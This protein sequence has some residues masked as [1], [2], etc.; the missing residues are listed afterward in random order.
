MG[1]ASAAEKAGKC[2]SS[3]EDREF[4]AS[5]RESRKLNAG[6]PVWYQEAWPRGRHIRGHS[7]THTDCTGRYLTIT[8][9][10]WCH[11]S[12]SCW[13]FLNRFEVLDTW[14]TPLH[15]ATVYF[16]VLELWI[17]TWCIWPGLDV[18]MIWL[19]GCLSV[20]WLTSCLTGSVLYDEVLMGGHD[21]ADAEINP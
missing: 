11:D 16:W 12:S 14:H 7:W 5:K 15:W 4:L 8:E 1:C 21:S 19:W 20:H 2:K 3:Q 13:D 10:I 6:A 17:L 9:E 18:A